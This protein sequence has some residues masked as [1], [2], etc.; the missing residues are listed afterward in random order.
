VDETTGPLVVSICR[1]LDGLPLAIELAADRLAEAGD[2]EAA[3]VASA[4]CEHFLSVA[5]AAALIC[6]GRSRAGGWRGWTPITRTCGAP[7]GT[8]PTTRNGTRQV[9]RLGAA[10]RR[11]WMTRSR[12]EEALALLAP[13]LT[14]PEARADPGLL[15]EAHIARPPIA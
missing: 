13:V 11:Y 3:A 1:R 10:L 15:L 8:P 9:L 7:L 6:P 12:E 5:Q 4:H 2:G 14:R